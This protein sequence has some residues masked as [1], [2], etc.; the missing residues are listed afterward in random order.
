MTKMFKTEE[1]AIEW[2]EMRLPIV[3][4]PS[5]PT[6][7]QFV[8]PYSSCH[9]YREVAKILGKQLFKEL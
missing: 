3:I 6:K 4:K 5:K 9:A 7:T 8:S 2:V 1:E